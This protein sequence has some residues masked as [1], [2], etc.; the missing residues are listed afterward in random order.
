VGFPHV[1][2]GH[3]QAPIPKTPRP[4]RSGVL[5]LRQEIKETGCSFLRGLQELLICCH[6][7]LRLVT[8]VRPLL[9]SKKLFPDKQSRTPSRLLTQLDT[10]IE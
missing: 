8:E 2:V 3:R 7:S 9:F 4:N 6:L 10:S 1:R 5:L